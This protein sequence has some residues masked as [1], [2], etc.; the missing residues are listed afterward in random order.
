MRRHVHKLGRMGPHFSVQRQNALKIRMTACVQEWR[1]SVV[2]CAVVDEVSR[3]QLVVVTG[4]C[5]C[6]IVL[7]LVYA[8]LNV[9]IRMLTTSVPDIITLDITS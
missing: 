8:Q 1:A 9:T 4:R 5:Q 3:R 2:P 7:L 6:R